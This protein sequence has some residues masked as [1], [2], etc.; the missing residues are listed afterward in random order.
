M[1]IVNGDHGIDS[2]PAEKKHR[3]WYRWSKYPLIPIFSYNRGNIRNTAS[4][5]FSWLMLRVWNLDDVK[6]EASFHIEDSGVRIGV[7]L[8][9]LRIFIVLVPFPDKVWSMLQFFHRKA[10]YDKMTREEQEEY[11]DSEGE[12]Q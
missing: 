8:P 3:T 4:F 6:F 5:S 2:V 12:Y 7:I 1:K 10:P 9:Y 11:F